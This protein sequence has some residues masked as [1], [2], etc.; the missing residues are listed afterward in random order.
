LRN[1]GII[2]LALASCTTA[3]ASDYSSW[4]NRDLAK[5]YKFYD[6]LCRGLDDED[7]IV[8]GCNDRDE[9]VQ[10]LLTRSYCYVGN[11]YDSTRWKKGPAF[12]WRRRGED[13]RCR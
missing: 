3:H 7:A 10:V 12:R 4:N 1:K 8:E 9:L 2:A 5:L 11:D 13:A 6:M